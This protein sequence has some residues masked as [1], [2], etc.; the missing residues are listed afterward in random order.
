MTVRNIYGPQSQSNVL[1][2]LGNNAS[3]INS[4]NDEIYSLGDFNINSYLNDFYIL[5]DKKENRKEQVSS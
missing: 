1:V 3:K 4:V 2:V 5:L